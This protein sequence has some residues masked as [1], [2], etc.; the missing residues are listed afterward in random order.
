MSRNKWLNKN[1]GDLTGKTVLITGSTSG[2]G[3]EAVRCLLY[4]NCSVI[5]AVRNI[6]KANMVKTN[7]LNEFPNANIKIEVVDQSKRTSIMSFVSSI[8]NNVIDS[9]T[10]KF[11][12]TAPEFN[13]KKEYYPQ[14][15]LKKF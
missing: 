5:M 1:I 7:L 13:N 9:F 15:N 14:M 10:S 2:V 12:A 4:K 11:L 6:E 3:L 8:K